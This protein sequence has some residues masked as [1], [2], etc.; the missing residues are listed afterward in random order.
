MRASQEVLGTSLLLTVL[1]LASNCAQPESSG[2]E[3]AAVAEDALVTTMARRYCEGLGSCCTERGFRFTQ[4]NC[5]RD[6]EKSLRGDLAQLPDSLTYDG[7]AAAACIE[8][9]QR[10]YAECNFDMGDLFS[11]PCVRIWQGSVAEGAPCTFD[12]ECAAPENAISE[13]ADEVCTVYRARS[14]QNGDACVYD[15]ECPTGS[16][17][18]DECLPKGREG[19]PCSTTCEAVDGDCLTRG[20]SPE[21]G[22]VCVRAE[23]LYCS[24]EG[25][26]ATLVAEGQPCGDSQEC[27]GAAFCSAGTC[28]RKLPDGATCEWDECIGECDDDGLC[29]GAAENED[30]SQ[31]LCDTAWQ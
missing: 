27:A 5:E 3:S 8:E 23:G 15:D 30:V 14:K 11:S 29:T 31:E 20:G 6:A 1:L 7:A 25:A 12:E 4:A 21:G 16:I 10:S 2:E 18:V 9:T 26:C 22:A 13:C 17:C 24:D 28:T 19:D